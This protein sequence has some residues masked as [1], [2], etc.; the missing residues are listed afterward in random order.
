LHGLVT[1]RADIFVVEQNCTYRDL[2]D[3]DIEPQTEHLWTADDKGPTSY[4]RVLAEPGGITRIGRVCTRQ[5]VRGQGLSRQLMTA[6]LTDSYGQVIVLDA[7]V[8]DAQ[9]HLVDWYARFG[10]VV[11]GSSYVEDGIAHVPM[12]RESSPVSR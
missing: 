11:A 6:V 2:D 4:L 5:D 9:A 10:F 3:R 8:L 1:L 7:V 12:R